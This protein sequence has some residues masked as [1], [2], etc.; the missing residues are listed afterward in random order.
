MDKYSGNPQLKTVLACIAA[1]TSL[2]F[3]AQVFAQGAGENADQ[4]TA[5]DSADLGKLEVTGSRI[6]RL[7]VEGPSPIVIVTRDEI[8]ERGFS[9]VYEALENL[10]QN[11]GDLQAEAFT[12]Q[13]TPNAQTLSL[14]S[15]GGGR[16][17]VLMNGRRVS[18]YPQPYNSESNF[19][20]FAQIPAEAI[21]RIEILT[22]SASAVYGSDAIAGVINV[23]LRDDITAPTLTAR[24]GT[25][26]DGGGDS[27]KISA[28]WGKQWDRASITIAAET[29]TIDPI[30]GKDRDYLDSVED[31]PQLAGQVPFSR[32]AL[33]YNGWYGPP[34]PENWYFDPGEQTCQDMQAD[35]VP[36][37]YAFRAGSGHYC[38]RDDYGDETIQNERD[39]SSVYLT[40]KADISD[41]TSVYADV[42]YWDSSAANKGFNMWWG[43]YDV[44]DENLVTTQDGILGD[45][46]TLQRIFHPDETGDQTN[47]FDES[48]TNA[49]IGFEGSFSN[50]WNWEAGITYSENDYH[51][52][53]ARFKEEVANDYFG[54]TEM[55]DICPLI[56]QFDEEGNVTCQLFQPL[57]SSAQFTIYEKLGQE[58]IDAV[59]GQMAIDSDASVWSAFA[60]FD[61]DLMEMKHGPLQFAAVLEFASQEYQITPDERL[62]DQTGNGWWGLSGTGGGGERDRSGVGVEFGIPLSEKLRATVATRYDHY[63]DKS[64]VGGAATYGIGL[65]YR[66]TDSLLLRASQNTSFRAPDMHYLYAAESG[67]FQVTRDIYQCRQEAIDLGTEYNELGCDLVQPA[68]TRHGVL[69]LA[70]E[71]GESLTFGFVFSPTSNLSLS[72]DFF[73]LEL[74]DAVRDMSIQQLLRDEADCQFG[75]DTNGGTVDTGSAFCTDVLIRVAREPDFFGTGEIQD[76]DVIAV[77]PVNTAYRKQRGFDAALDYRMETQS[78]GDLRFRVDY[79]HVLKDERQL[80][81]H[82]EVERDYRD[83]LQNF[84]ARS[85]INMT[86]T[87]DYK[88]FSGTLFGH[89]LGSMP[90]WQETGR[91][92]PWFV[93]NGSA[94]MRF[95]D[96]KLTASLLVN[97]LLNTRPPKDDGFTTWPFF[98]R[99]QYNAV[100]RQTFV[101]ASYSFE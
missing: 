52:R 74:T 66:P 20:N 2:L 69:E 21:E 24:F 58:D 71:E 87:W 77:N 90:N 101:Q 16:T 100:G 59:M 28:V 29:Q 60:E 26:A 89:R 75:V 82:D 65:E 55:I 14:R 57:Y 51:E 78:A 30:F 72:V 96:D 47:T 37:V 17:L 25:T 62:L 11:T 40:Y 23:I 43:S 91:L 61:G 53:Q 80:Y 15:L 31:A 36:Y 5:E 81:D 22:G 86:A 44:W 49:T 8:E 92:G 48:A 93:Y 79:T 76:L 18:D 27:T 34:T 50:F 1:A 97:N 95:M 54:G 12:N 35:G 67:F 68:G 99:G 84:N 9:S 19:F 33:K 73:E 42:M 64:D 98:Y 88:K 6:K 70:E 38:G 32:A 3:S 46:V 10:T 83:N 85:T 94:T 45:W 4:A 7:D 56:G 41:S 39:R 13:F 63:S